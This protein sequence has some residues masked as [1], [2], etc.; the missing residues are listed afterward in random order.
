MEIVVNQSKPAIT[1]QDL[2][3]LDWGLI[4]YKLSLDKQ[5]ELVNQVATDPTHSAH[6]AHPGF[7]IFCSHPPI[8][9]LGRQT[10]AED[11][12]TWSGDTIEV[13]RGGRATYHG[14][15]QL[16]VY[17]ILNIKS[18]RKQRGP[19]EIRGFLRDFETAIV[20]SFKFYQIESFG[21]SNENIDDTG[22]WV[23]TENGIKKITSMGIA[24]KKWV[25]YHG[26]AI[27]IN[28]DPEAF[29][30]INPCGYSALKMISMEQL[31]GHSIDLTKF[32]DVLKK[33]L[34]FNL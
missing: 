16:V 18:P 4:D 30:G 12:T 5:L 28:H 22:V 11:I 32:K 23:Q 29:A 10:K 26:A 25:T 33:N 31:V 9:T 6:P 24:V 7:I 17:V 13:S 14:P 1:V 20:N 27:N 34:Q 3:V 21:R 15:S 8:V 19:Q 2:V